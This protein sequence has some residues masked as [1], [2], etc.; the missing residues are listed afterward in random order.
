MLLGCKVKL[1]PSL[2]VDVKAGFLLLLILIENTWLNLHEIYGYNSK[3][4]SHKI[5]IIM[6]YSRE[7][8]E[9]LMNVRNA[10][11]VALL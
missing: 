11:E 8:I 1:L 5:D 10:G 6:D 9:K 3:L 4:S 7:L 2:E